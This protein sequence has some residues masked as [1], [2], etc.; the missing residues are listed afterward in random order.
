MSAEHKAS[1]VG[2]KGLFEES[3]DDIPTLLELEAIIIGA[4]EDGIVD[5]GPADV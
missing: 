4:L 5:F 1:K 3:M 2:S